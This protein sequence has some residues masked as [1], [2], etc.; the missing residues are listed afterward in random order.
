MPR[1]IVTASD[2]YCVATVNHHPAW[3]AH[4]HVTPLQPVPIPIVN[5]Y[6]V[7]SCKPSVKV[8]PA[9]HNP[10]LLHSLFQELLQVA[11]K[12]ELLPGVP[13]RGNLQGFTAGAQG[14]HGDDCD[15]ICVQ[16]L[17]NGISAAP[18]AWIIKC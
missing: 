17:L 16:T 15:R 10:N 8:Q 12:E 2:Q 14:C 11:L 1:S 7:S 9:L 4:G 18:R 6:H 13:V 5:P 3:T